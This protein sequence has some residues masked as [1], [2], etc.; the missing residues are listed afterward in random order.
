MKRPGPDHKP[1]LM[2]EAGDKTPLAKY[3][4]A[5]RK[6]PRLGQSRRPTFAGCGAAAAG[7]PEGLYGS[8]TRRGIPGNLSPT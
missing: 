8:I 6:A 3:A 4:L 1:K 2:T 7:S 5:V